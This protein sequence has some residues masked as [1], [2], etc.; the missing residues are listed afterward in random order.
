MLVRTIPLLLLAAVPA[1]CWDGFGHQTVGF[2]AQKYFTEEANAT[3]G[4][5]I[6][7]NE[8]FDIGD[9]A[10][11]ADTVRGNENLPWSKNW[12]FISE[13]IPRPLEG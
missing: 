12:H 10:A 6:G 5:L 3:I 13:F 8:R 11:W 4:A 9:A 2:V 1:I 7:L